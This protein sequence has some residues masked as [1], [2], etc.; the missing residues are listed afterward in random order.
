MRFSF[1]DGEFRHDAGFHTAEECEIAAVHGSIRP[2][3]HNVDAGFGGIGLAA[4]EIEKGCDLLEF[5][6]ERPS[7]HGPPGTLA[8]AGHIHPG[9]IWCERQRLP[10][11][12]VVVGLRKI[13]PRLS[14]PLLF[15]NGLLIGVGFN[16][17]A[18][19]Y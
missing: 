12:I 13:V 19:P 14:N 10:R 8:G 2:L 7:R 15:E 11:T 6:L 18:S 4:L 1:N 17:H 3:Q 16:E 9:C 5:L